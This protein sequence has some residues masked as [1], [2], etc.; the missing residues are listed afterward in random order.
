MLKFTG[1][2]NDAEKPALLFVNVSWCGHCVRAKP[3]MN[4]VATMMGSVV[5]VYSVDGDKFDGM[6]KGWGVSS[7]PTILYVNQGRAV[8]YDGDRTADL[9]VGWVCRQSSSSAPHGFCPASQ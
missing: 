2:L 8:A 4:K 6:V 3:E 9:S 5:P 7:F 1:T